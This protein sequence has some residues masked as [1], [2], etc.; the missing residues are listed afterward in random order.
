V[1]V[2]PVPFL[3]AGFEYKQGARYG[4]GFAN[5][6][7]WDAHAAWFVSPSLT[8]IG[9]YAYTGDAGSTASASGLGG[10]FVASAQCTF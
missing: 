10:G 5:A 6:S 2:I 9:A 7:Y 3:A 1:D 4:N 8:L